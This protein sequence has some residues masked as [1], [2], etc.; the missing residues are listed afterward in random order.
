[1]VRSM[2]R[3]DWGAVS[4]ALPGLVVPVLALT[5]G[6][7]RGLHSAAPPGLEWDMALKFAHGTEVAQGEDPGLELIGTGVEHGKK[8]AKRNGEEV[9]FGVGSCGN[10]SAWVGF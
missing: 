8:H 3:D 1:M 9:G 6:L 5:H 7:R 2:W 10:E 4:F